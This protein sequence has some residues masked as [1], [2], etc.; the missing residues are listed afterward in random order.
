L[1]FGFVVN[2]AVLVGSLIGL[3]GVLSLEYLSVIVLGA[4][5]RDVTPIRA[6]F[7]EKQMSR[8]ALLRQIDAQIEECETMLINLVGMHNIFKDYI[9][10]LLLSNAKMA[11][12]LSVLL[13]L[14]RIVAALNEESRAQLVLFR[15]L[16]LAEINAELDSLDL[17]SESS[18]LLSSSEETEEDTLIEDAEPK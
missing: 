14:G 12:D 17:D 2:E 1:H 6:R 9:P 16:I 3:I 13:H 7:L 18:L 8:R 10:G 5:S 4:Y 11:G 15:A